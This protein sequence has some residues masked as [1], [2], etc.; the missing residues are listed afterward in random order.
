MGPGAGVGEGAGGG[1]AG[2][3]AALGVGTGGA[4]S[5]GLTGSVL[6]GATVRAAGASEDNKG[7]VFRTTGFSIG[8]GLGSDGR[9][10][11]GSGFAT[12]CGV[13][14]ATSLTCTGAPEARSASSLIRRTL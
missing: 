14:A 5:T 11:M 10:G 3:G 6:A 12:G 1:G 8:L 9:T 2:A 4:G 13:G 7:A